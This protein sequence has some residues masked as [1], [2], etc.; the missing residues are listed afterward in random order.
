MKGGV[1]SLGVPV[2][3]SGPV[4]ITDA[5]GS[6]LEASRGFGLVAATPHLWGGESPSF[7]PSVFWR[8]CS[9]GQGQWPLAADGSSSCVGFS[10]WGHIVSL[11]GQQWGEPHSRTRM[12]QTHEL[13]I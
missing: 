3:L 1:T 6:L 9:P 11:P 8:R 7:W 13:F 10:L 5:P 4:P 2:R 12:P